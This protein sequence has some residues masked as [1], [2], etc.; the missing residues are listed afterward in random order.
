MQQDAH[1]FLNFLLNTISEILIGNFI[2]TFL[3]FFKC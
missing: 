2:L 1:E 3:I